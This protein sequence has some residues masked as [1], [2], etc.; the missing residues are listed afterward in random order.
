MTWTKAGE[1]KIARSEHGAI[2]NGVKM[3]IA[4]GDGNYKSESCDV[5]DGSVTC[6]AQAPTLDNYSLYPEMFLVPDSFCKNI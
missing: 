6:I 5:V 4:G 2:H 1:L 3:I